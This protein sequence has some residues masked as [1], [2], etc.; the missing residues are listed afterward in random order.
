MSWFHFVL[1]ELLVYTLKANNEMWSEDMK[2]YNTLLN[3]YN[4]S[5]LHLWG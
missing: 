1:F 4:S 3:E 5:D 2:R